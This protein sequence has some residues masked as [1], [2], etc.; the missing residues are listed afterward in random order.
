MK[1]SMIATGAAGF[2]SF[3]EKALFEH[4]AMAAENETS[5]KEESIKGLGKGKIG[6]VEISR[7]IIGSNL[8]GGGAHARNLMYVSELMERYFTDDKILETL[9]LC[10]ENGINTN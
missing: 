2:M 10:E 9:Q 7:V 8:F 1:K 4:Q 3:E 6:D 5:E